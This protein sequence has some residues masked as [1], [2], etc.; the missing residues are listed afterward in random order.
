MALKVTKVLFALW[1]GGMGLLW[2]YSCYTSVMDV[3][4]GN[5]D[6]LEPGHTAGLMIAAAVFFAV[7]A[8]GALVLFFVRKLFIE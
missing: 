8:A 1:T 6:A 7:W 5:P 2:L 4:D 3:T